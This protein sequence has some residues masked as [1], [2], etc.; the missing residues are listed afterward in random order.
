MDLLQ[1]V[2]KERLLTLPAEAI[3]RKKSIIDILK[4]ER[5]TNA[6]RERLEA[7]YREAVK[8]KDDEVGCPIRIE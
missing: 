7:K 3:K 8:D 6:M 5:R 4:R 2:I 1:A